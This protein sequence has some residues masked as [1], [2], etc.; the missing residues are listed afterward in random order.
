MFQKRY[1]NESVGEK[2]LDVFQH[3]YIINLSDRA[4]RRREIEGQLA[5]VGL[6]TG[7]PSIS[8]F[9]AVK[10][11]EAGG[12][13]SV[14]AQ[15]CFMSHLGVLDLALETGL[16]RVLI[17]E[18]DMD[19]TSRFIHAGVNA[20]E[21][22][23]RK[24]WHFVHGGLRSSNARNAGPVLRPLSPE[25]GLT[26]THFIGLAAPAIGSAAAY[27]KTI[28]SRPPGHPEGGPM[29]VDGAY[30]WFRKSNPNLGAYYFEP[31][32]AVQRASRTDIHCNKWYDVMPGFAQAAHWYR[33]LFNKI[34]R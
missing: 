28:A 29:H 10:P 25:T 13:P 15:G 26:Q 30:S 12:W 11:S 24:T 27:L 1:K 34:N 20:L 7:H 4:D 16:D 22:L 9:N 23:D 8:F 19:W 14:G 31:E 3:I 18:D 32:I 17:L 33:T 6:S 2:I 21:E 5:R